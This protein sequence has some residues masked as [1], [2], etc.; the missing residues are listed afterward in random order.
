M[1]VSD[2]IADIGTA[3]KENLVPWKEGRGYAVKLLIWFLKKS[4]GVIFR[5]AEKYKGALNGLEI[6]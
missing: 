4:S 6:A 2:S 5:A 3:R 1:N